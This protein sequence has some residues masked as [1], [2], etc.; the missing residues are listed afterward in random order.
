MPVN[1]L[2]QNV[3]NEEDVGSN[4]L[5]SFLTFSSSSPMVA[6]SG[7]VEGALPLTPP[8]KSIN[9]SSIILYNT[10]NAFKNY[11]N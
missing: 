9:I 4:S 7:G 10:I 3:R 6:E 5:G 8:K 1:F 2:I 11:I